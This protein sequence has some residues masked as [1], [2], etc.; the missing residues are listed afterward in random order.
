MGVKEKIKTN[1]QRNFGQKYLKRL[2]DIIAKKP[3]LYAYASTFSSISNKYL[4]IFSIGS[5]RDTYAGEKP[6]GFGS[7]F[8]PFELFH[9][10]GI[11]PFLPEIIGGFTAGLALWTRH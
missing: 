9:A 4:N 6:V 2:L 3:V 5:I 7:L 11:S 8:L 10:T 1:I